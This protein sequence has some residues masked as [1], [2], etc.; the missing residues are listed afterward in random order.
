MTYTGHPGVPLL[1]CSVRSYVS[2]RANDEQSGTIPNT[3]IL[4]SNVR[5]SPTERK[6]GRFGLGGSYINSVS[7]VHQVTLNE[8]CDHHILRPQ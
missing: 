5:S 2:E 3:S 7:F 8:M 1:S 4:A 6:S